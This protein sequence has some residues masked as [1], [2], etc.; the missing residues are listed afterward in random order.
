M[1][2]LKTVVCNARTP[3]TLDDGRIVPVGTACK[4]VDVS[5]EHNKQLVDAGDLAVVESRGRTA[6]KSKQEEAK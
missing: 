4:Q 3:V 6:T 1:A 5:T 2:D